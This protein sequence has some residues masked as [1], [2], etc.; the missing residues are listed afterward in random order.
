VLHPTQSSHTFGFALEVYQRALFITVEEMLRGRL[1]VLAKR[2]E[3]EKRVHAYKKLMEIVLF[4]ST[5]TTIP[6]DISCERQFQEFRKQK[7]RIGS[8]DLRI[9]ST[10][11]V[12]NLIVVT[13]NQRDF[14]HIP[15]LTLEDW[16]VEAG[17][18]PAILFFYFLNEIITYRL[19]TPKIL[20]FCIAATTPALKRSDG[21]GA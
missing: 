18:K 20:F 2:S 5:I 4:F 14:R 3:G 8:Q 6:F 1:A 9:A 17:H 19:V 7:I 21:K 12:H 10:A 15:R 16:T 13:R 11:I